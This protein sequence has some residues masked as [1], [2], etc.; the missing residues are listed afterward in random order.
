MVGQ[1][2]AVEVAVAAARV[3]GPPG[4]PDAQSYPMILQTARSTPLATFAAAPVRRARR[5]SAGQKQHPDVLRRG[6]PAL[7][8]HPPN[9]NETVPPFHGPQGSTS[10]WARLRTAL[11]RARR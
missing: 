1:R 2:R 10:R 9:L 11:G 7:F 3:A 5:R 8:S 4:G 6:L